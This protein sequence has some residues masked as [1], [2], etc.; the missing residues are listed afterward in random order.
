MGYELSVKVL[1]LLGP[2]G[3]AAQLNSPSAV[4]FAQ[5][6]PTPKDDQLGM[7]KHP[8]AVLMSGQSADAAGPS[9]VLTRGCDLRL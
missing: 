7:K 5:A 2:S 3:H 6:G 4:P 8:V 9:N 1:M